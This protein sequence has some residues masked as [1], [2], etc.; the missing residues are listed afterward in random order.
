MVHNYNPG[1]WEAEVGRWPGV[2]GPPGPPVERLCFKIVFKKKEKE[3]REKSVL[4]LHLNKYKSGYPHDNHMASEYSSSREADHPISP[5][6]SFRIN[7]LMTW[8]AA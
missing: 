4:F 3:K 2:W 1:T 6:I 7:N 8:H 5:A